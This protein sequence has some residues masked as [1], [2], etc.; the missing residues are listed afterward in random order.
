MRAS[1]RRGLSTAVA[2]LLVGGLAVA[3]G[4]DGDSGGDGT[5]ELTVD[6]FGEPGYEELY[7]QYEASHP[8]VKIKQRKVSSLDDFKPRIQQWMAT[9]SGAGDVV[10]LEEGILPLYMQQPDK[11]VNLFDHGGKELEQNFVSWKWQAGV[12]P[13][14]K[15]LV[16][17][18]TDVGAL[19]MC[20]R[21]DLFEK[22]G[23]P[24]ERDEVSKLWPTWDEYLKVGQ[25]FQSKMKDSK[26]LDGPTAVWRVTVLQQAGAGPGYSY[27]DKSNKLV[28]DSNPAVKSSFDTAL[29]FEQNKLTA[30]MSIFTPPWQTAL[31]RDTFAT[32]PCPSWM[33]G[34]IKEFSGDYGKGKWDVASVPG[35]SGY[36]GGSWLA[37]PKQTDHA[38]EAAELAKF[39]TSP[40]GQVARSRPRTSS[41]P[42]RRPRR[43]RRWPRPRT[44]TSTTRR[45]VRSSARWWRRPSPS[46]SAR[47]TRTCARPSRT[48]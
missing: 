38:K 28:F 45:S 18:G 3:C 44:S 30:D 10:M 14:G 40:E 46:T 16:G 5:V 36:W 39:L 21:T 37:V 42:R 41:R 17:L 20:Y 9:G 1:M 32:V 47:R 2:A 48:S 13:D 23:L 8:N 34:G 33:L 11:F 7:K 19:A 22:A 27:F 31:K 15:Q 6:V 4:D 25:D 29:K 12:T 43:T 26:W 35:G 24:T